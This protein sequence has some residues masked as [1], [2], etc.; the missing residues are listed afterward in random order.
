MLRERRFHHQVRKR[1]PDLGPLRGFNA[2]P[3]L[4]RLYQ[5]GLYANSFQPAFKLAGERRDGALALS[6]AA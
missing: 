5:S 2:A 4:A 1:E 3:T 6:S